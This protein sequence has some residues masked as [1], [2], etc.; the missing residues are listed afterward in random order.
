MTNTR[1][2][3]AALAVGLAVIWALPSGGAAAGGFQLREKDHIAIIGNT[4]AERMQYDG[5]LETLLQARFPTYDLVIRNLGFSG[6][7]VATRLRSKNFGTPDEWLSGVAAPI[8]GYNENR[9]AGTDTKADVVF[10]FFGYNES[11]AG[12]AGLDAFK[13]QLGEW[14]AHTLAQKYNG[15]SAPRLVVFSPIAHEDL[16]NPDLPDGRENNTRLELYTRAMAEVV[17]KSKEVTFVDLFTPSRALYAAAKS[18]LTMQGVHL[19]SEGNR[20]LAEVIDRELFGAAPRRQEPFLEKVRAAVLDKNFHWFNRYRVTD[21]FA[22]YGD[23]AFLTFVRDNPR[24]VTPSPTAP[25]DKG[26]VLPTNYEVLE[27]EVSI[28]DVMTGNRDRR[29]WAVARGQDPQGANLKIADTDTP[30]HIDAQT[31]EPGKGPNG[32]HLY[33]DGTEAVQKMTIGNGLKVELFASEKE[34]PE[35]V[36]PVQMSFDTKGRLWVAC[37]KSYPHWQPNSPMEDKLLILE[38]TDGDGK[39]D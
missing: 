2:F 8:G 22:T 23:R 30:P 15:K 9:L 18:P 38:D 25:V 1:R 26:K 5:W 16:K 19:N 36:K 13:Q 7:E 20:R 34:F 35:L 31:N 24:N 12:Q 33:L 27:R 37:W 14:I 29:I 28:L 4:L 32:E 21:G 3:L 11:Y 10:A 17:A 39:A 6:D